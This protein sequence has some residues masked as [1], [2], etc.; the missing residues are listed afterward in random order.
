[1]LASFAR[2]AKSKLARLCL[3]GSMLFGLS[4]CLT[5]RGEQ[6]M[7]GLGYGA[8]Q[9]YI[10]ESVA[11]E[12]YGSPQNK[13]ETAYAPREER[14]ESPKFFNAAKETSTDF[15]DLRDIFYP[16]EKIYV[17]GIFNGGK[18]TNFVLALDKGEQ[19]PEDLVNGS[20]EVKVVLKGYMEGKGVRSS[21]KFDANH[22]L[23]NFGNNFR[24]Y[25]LK[26]DKIVGN[27]DFVIM[28]QRPS[29]YGRNN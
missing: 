23:N 28:N 14:R 27:R 4:G 25:W 1:M 2:G 26:N 16:G 13:D 6:M 12:V 11:K 18:I 20:S 7:R 9:T 19:I 22:L 3:G 8:I 29:R 17:V 21:G 24:V 5:P 10:N 15:E